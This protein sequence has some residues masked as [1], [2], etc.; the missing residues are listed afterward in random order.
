MNFERNLTFKATSKSSRGDVTAGV[1]R[2]IVAGWTGRDPD[3]VEAHIREL[4]ELGVP[5][6]KTTP[7]FYRVSASNLTQ[8]D[9]IQVAGDSSTGEVECVIFNLPDGLWIGVGSD[10]TDR[11]LEA[12]GVTLSKQICQ[13]PVSTEVWSFDEVKGHFDELILRSWAT[14]DG[15]RRRYQ[16]G[17]AAR[18]LHPSELIARY[19]ADKAF[20]PG[21]AMFCGTLPVHDTIRFATLF[22]MELHDPVLNRSLK[23]SYAVEA[24]AII[25]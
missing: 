2:L 6:P 16:E 18:M 9:R 7:C 19:S 4:E 25:D 8:S 23:H 24:L 10:H 1:S 11:Q 20:E 12:V 14:I 5:R 21:D 13:K 15:V 22:E 17:S 3:A